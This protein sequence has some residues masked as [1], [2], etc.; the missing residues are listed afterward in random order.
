[1]TKRCAL[2][3]VW[4]ALI[5]AVASGQPP[6]GI[7]RLS[8]D[9][10]VRA[11]IEHNRQMQT[12]RLQIQKAEADLA[13]AKTRRLPIF[14][15]ELKASQLVT[16]VSFAF[17][18]GAFGDFP[19]TGPIP[20]TDT[21]ISV[22][23]QPA[24]YVSSQVSQPLTQLVQIGL[25]IANAETTRDLERERAREQQLTLV[26]TVK[27]VYFAILQTESA[28]SAG[29]ENVALY[30]EIERT[31]QDR[32]VQRVALRSDAMDV[33]FQLAKE[34]LA[35]IERANTLASYK[36]QLNQLLGRDVRTPF[37][38]DAVAAISAF[39]VDLEAAQRQAL[40]SRPDVREAQLTLR[41]A[42]ISRRLTK[43]DRLPDVSVALGYTS[44]FNVD[45]LPRNM[46]TVGVQVTWEP[47]DWGRK[48][49][50]LAAKT[51]TV[52]QAQHSVRDAEDRAVLE[53]NSRFRALGEK[54]AL[55]R[56]AEMAQ[57]AARERLRV[58]TNQYQVQ[59]A[60]LNDVLQVRADVAGADDQYQQALLAFWTAKADFEQ[61]L[62]EEVI[63]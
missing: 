48:G 3:L 8:L 52:Q 58:K 40:A 55:L 31:V 63:P 47:F 61:A 59:A 36:E 10:A 21:T 51:Y 62:G 54:R 42:E 5:P 53:I 56:V 57:G 29:R 32:L 23:R 17:P 46:A 15:S 7:E 6:A 50:E 18:Q 9:A 13:V 49:R 35:Q 12:A 37:A 22:P 33:Q 25:N 34:E 2:A 45:V 11:A 24:Y 20:A 38:I 1:M 4:A 28:L 41:Q 19:A 44:N 27:R 30:R 26:N 39:D 14:E 60:L 43:A 16:P